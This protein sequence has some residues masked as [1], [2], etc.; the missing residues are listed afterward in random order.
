MN[1]KPQELKELLD[2]IG[3]YHE[4]SFRTLRRL[5]SERASHEG[6]NLVLQAH[7]KELE[8]KLS[9]ARTRRAKAP[10]RGS[11]PDKARSSARNGKSSRSG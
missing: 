2:I 8:E 6:K 5:D 4:N 9:M 11:R 7:V 1:L 10:R 3:I